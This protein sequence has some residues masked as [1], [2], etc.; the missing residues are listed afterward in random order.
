[1]NWG[2]R[3]HGF[4]T[5]GSRREEGMEVRMSNPPLSAVISRSFSEGFFYLKEG[6][7]SVQLILT[8][9]NNQ[10][11]DSYREDRAIAEGS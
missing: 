4:E 11:S 8:P 9:R 2:M 10:W 3:T 5:E 7:G 6:M 1:M